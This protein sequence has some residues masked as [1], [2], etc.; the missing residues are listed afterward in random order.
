MK[1]DDE[2]R[3]ID[4]KLK[5]LEDK[6]RILDLYKDYKGEDKVVSMQEFL[7]LEEENGG[8][9]FSCHSKINSLDNKIKE[10][11]EGDLAVITGP[12]GQGKTSLCQTLNVS[13]EKQ[14]IPCLWFTF[15]LGGTELIE[16]MP[17][18]TGGF[19][20]RKNKPSD[21]TWL[22][23]RICEAIAKHSIKAVFIDHLHFLLGLDILSRLNNASL[24]IGKVTS[25]LKSIAIK[26]SIMIFLVAHSTKKNQFSEP[27]LEDLRDSS[28][29]GQNADFVFIVWRESEED[30]VAYLKIAKNRRTGTLGKVKLRYNNKLF[31]EEIQ[32][33]EC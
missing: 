5:E 31:R 12:T 17:D 14:G 23:Q 30:N 9:S 16:K 29:I 8:S 24:Y 15:E 11:R 22:E 32:I 20:P 33:D 6:K 27:N 25:E 2:V 7:E 19:L 3:E 10:L 26:W 28:F 1:Q 4:K 18:G 21:M 13:F